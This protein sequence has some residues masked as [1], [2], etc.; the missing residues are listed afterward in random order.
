MRQCFKLRHLNASHLRKAICAILPLSQQSAN[1]VAS[2]ANKKLKKIT[3][4][5]LIHKAIPGDAE[6]GNL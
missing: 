2:G 4:F 5:C 6:S 3:E 1:A